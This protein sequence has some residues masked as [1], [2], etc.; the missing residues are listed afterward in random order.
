MSTPERPD[1]VTPQAIIDAAIDSG[2]IAGTWLM[3]GADD[4]LAFAEQTACRLLATDN[5]EA[6]PGYRVLTPDETSGVITVDEVR[7]ASTFLQRT[8]ADDSW[9]VLMI[10]HA[11]LVNTQGMNAFLISLEEPPPRAV[12]LL[13]TDQPGRLLATVRS[14]TRRIRLPVKDIA[15]QMRKAAQTMPPEFVAAAGSYA[16]GSPERL[17]TFLDHQGLWDDLHA[18][19]GKS[20]HEVEDFVRKL[21]D[22]AAQHLTMEM[23]LIAVESSCR[24]SLTPRHPHAS[25]P[26]WLSLW[27]RLVRSFHDCETLNLSTERA[28]VA[29]IQALG[30]ASNHAR[31]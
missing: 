28:L 7:Q 8:S 29:A 27:E 16:Q 18:A 13:V 10:A 1:H 15:D 9:R 24:E 19:R 17:K 4:A 20:F 23:L 31:A 2:R 25:L 14:R 30:N 12:I 5:P 6:H 26:R 3:T 21:E 11:H 22:S